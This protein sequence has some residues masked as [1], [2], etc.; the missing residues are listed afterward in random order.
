MGGVSVPLGQMKQNVSVTLDLQA[1][2]VN[3]SNFKYI[4]HSIFHRKKFVFFSQTQND[5][6]YFDR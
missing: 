1:I 6:L 3:V 2:A 5:K 4:L